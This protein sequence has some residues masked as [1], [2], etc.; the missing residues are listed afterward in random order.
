MK[1]LILV[2]GGQRSGKSAYAQRRALEMA[3]DP[4]YVATSRIW[5]DEHRARVE[6]HRADRGTQWTTLEIEKELG[7][8]DLRGRVVVV[9]CVTLWAANFFFDNDGDVER[10][11]AELRAEFDRLASRQAVLLVVTNEIGMGE[12]PQNPLQRRFTDLQGRMNQ[13]IAARADEVV[14]MISGVPVKIAP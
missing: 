8:A 13:Y 12:M 11:E 9:D 10:T 5:D 2:T 6:R 7:A 1:K 3:D 14:L 4:I